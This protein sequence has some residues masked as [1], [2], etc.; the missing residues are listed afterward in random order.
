MKTPVVDYR[1]FRLTKLNDPEFS[2]LKLLGGWIGYF[3]LYFLTENFIPM[4]RM[5]VIHCGLDDIIPFNEYFLIFYCSWYALI[6]ISLLYFLLYDID[7]FRRLQVFII[8]TQAVAMVVYIVYP[9]IQ[10]LRPEV[11]P[12]ENALTALMAFIYDFDTPTGVCPSLHV[13]YTMGIVSVWLK[14]RE[15]PTWT[16]ALLVFLL[17]M[18]SVS[19][20]F[21][22]QHSVVDIIA[23]IPLGMLAEYLVFG[24][25]QL[26]RE[27]KKAARLQ[28]AQVLSGG[29]RA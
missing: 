10:L 1:Q 3:I 13:A 28:K 2:H 26:N 7:S 17:V 19:T 8:I 5:H 24:R 16:R 18:I 11:F 21:V 15:T 12:R 20:A 9:S 6:V 23:A 14:R 25:T 27:L 22:K 4:E 29:G